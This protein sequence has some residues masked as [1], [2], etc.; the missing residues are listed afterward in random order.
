MFT[1]REY[2]AGS[3]SSVIQTITMYPL[4][5]L[6]VYKQSNTSKAIKVNNLYKG[7]KYPLIFEG[8]AGSLL[9]GTYYNLNKYYSKETSSFITGIIV[10]SLMNPFEIHKTKNQLHIK[11]HINMFR[12][13]HLTIGRETIGN[14]IYFGSYDYFRK[15]CQLSPSLSGGLCGAIMWTI[16]YPLDNFKTNYTMNN[17]SIKEFIKN[18]NLFKGYKYCLIRA[19]PAN[20]IVFEIYEKL[21]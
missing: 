11:K 13:L 7:I 10:G 16:V 17:M 9:F 6:K 5:T 4:D 2:L 8:F 12:G 3:I 20:F 19:V 15:E 14:Y 1:L 18:N 21:I